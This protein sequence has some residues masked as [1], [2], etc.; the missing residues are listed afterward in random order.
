MWEQLKQKDRC[1]TSRGHATISCISGKKGDECLPRAWW[2]PRRNHLSSLLRVGSSGGDHSSPS[3]LTAFVITRMSSSSTLS[4]ALRK[5]DD[6]KR[7]SFSS[8]SL[9]GLCVESLAE[10]FT[11]ALKSLDLM[12]HIKRCDTS[13]LSA[14]ALLLLPVAPGLR[15]LSR[16]LNQR[17]PPRSPDLLRVNAH[18]RHDATPSWSA[19]DPGPRLPW[20]R[21]LRCP[22]DQPGRKRRARVSLPL[23][24]QPLMC[25]S[26]PRLML[27]AEESVILGPHS[28]L[29]KT[30]IF[31]KKRATIFFCLP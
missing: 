22:P 3:S 19:K 16:Q 30:H 2:C 18:A 6:A 13:S 12:C 26:T 31:S 28:G 25:L 8:G 4:L 15:R 17:Q 5:A 21:R 9:F 11:E 24:K 27:G 23:R 1:K 20:I 10:H 7:A 29:N 14:P